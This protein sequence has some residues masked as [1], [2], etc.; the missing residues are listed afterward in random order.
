MVTA[1]L[2]G[3]DREMLETRSHSEP[4][5]RRWDLFLAP[6]AADPRDLVG[7]VTRCERVLATLGL[8]LGTRSRHLTRR[9]RERSGA[10][11]TG[12]IRPSAPFPWLRTEFNSF[13]RK[14]FKLSSIVPPPPGHPRDR[15]AL[16]PK[17]S[18]RSVTLWPDNRPNGFLSGTEA[19][20]WSPFFFF[21]QNELGSCEKRSTGFR[22]S[23][24]R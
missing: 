14:C 24:S 21:V 15:S 2:V 12:T 13:A 7:S 5:A 16:S 10:C 17:M 23:L 8:S 6:L 20:D 11:R 3:G 18:V 4:D 1:V 9:D 19:A 22:N